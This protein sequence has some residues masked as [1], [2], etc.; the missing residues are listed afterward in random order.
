M[1]YIKIIAV[2]TLVSLFSAGV[3]SVADLLSRDKIL[4]NE[5]K[6]FDQAIT[7][8]I[9]EAKRVEQEGDIY[10]VFDAKDDLAAYIF[11]AQGQGY[12]GPIK[13]ICGATVSLDKL[14]GIE[15]LES[16]ETPGLGARINEASFKGQF[17]GLNALEKIQ[18]QAITGATVSS[19]SV[20]AIV[21]KRVEEI[22]GIIKDR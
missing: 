20:V 19:R 15:I 22:R 17:K 9:P 2:L 16:T 3:L 11:L 5:K 1:K 6:A 4:A 12:Q 10:K 8:I 18:I 14:L 13:V 7:A 21:N